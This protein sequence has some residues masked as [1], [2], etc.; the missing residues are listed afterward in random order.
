MRERSR[1]KIIDVCTESARWKRGKNLYAFY[2][3][4][5]IPNFFL[6]KHFCTLLQITA[7]TLC[8]NVE[9]KDEKHVEK[10]QQIADALSV[11]Y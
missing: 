7:I 8:G 1:K 10:C 4:T 5:F 2:H 6:P 9:K 11:S 3:A